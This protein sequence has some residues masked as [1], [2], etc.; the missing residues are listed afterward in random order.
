MEAGSWQIDA[1]APYTA[2]NVLIP[3]QAKTLIF[4]ALA[5][6]D[7]DPHNVRALRMGLLM[8]VKAVKTAELGKIQ[9]LY[10]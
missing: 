5:G 7:R 9:K 3:A 6:S 10:N 4:A 8:F 1:G 2:V